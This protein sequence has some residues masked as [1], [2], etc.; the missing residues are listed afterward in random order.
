MSDGYTKPVTTQGGSHVVHLLMTDIKHE[1]DESEQPSTYELL[2]TLKPICLHGVVHACSRL[3][4]VEPS[5]Q[6]SRKRPQVWVK[7]K[8]CEMF[9][10][11][12]PRK[13]PYAITVC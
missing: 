1:V 8:Q 12:R 10:R 3:I 2:S 13:S 4:L 6:A 7:P 9:E 11:K 5:T